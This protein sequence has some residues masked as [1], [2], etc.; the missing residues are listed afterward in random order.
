MRTTLNALCTQNSV[1]WRLVNQ[2]YKLQT[3]KL[4]RPIVH[5]N[6]KSYTVVALHPKLY[7]H[8]IAVTLIK[9]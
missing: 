6:S 2:V 4:A 3:A 9:D 7:L 8:F 5:P 1:E